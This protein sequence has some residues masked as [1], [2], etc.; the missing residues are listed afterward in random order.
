MPLGMNLVTEEFLSAV[1]ALPKAELHLHIEGT[2]EPAMLMRLAEKHSVS[3][4]YKSE[5]EVHAA[6]DFSDLQSFLDIYYLGAGVLI[7]EAD[8]HDL[9]FTYL[10]RCRDEGIVHT[11]IMFDPQTHTDR[12]ISFGT[13]MDGFLK[14]MESAQ[15]DWGQSSA[16]IM[17]F[18]RHLD[19]DSAFQTLNQAEPYRAHIQSVGLD[20]SE[21]GHPPEKFAEVYAEA[22]SQGYRPVAHA[23]EEGPPEYI[24]GAL[25]TL[26]V[27]R[28]DHGVRCLEDDALVQHLVE[29][30]IPLTVCPL[31]NVRLCVFPEMS[32]HPLLD[33]LDRGL[34][35]TV[36]SDDPPYFGGYLMDNFESLHEN[37]SLDLDQAKRL[38][39]NSINSS[40]LSSE[41]KEDWLTQLSSP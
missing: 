40:F 11:E 34:N 26:E 21:L 32:Q 8:F 10:S 18:L 14:A 13:V 38:A 33:M 3:L 15:R 30:Q 19:E 37:L 17:S 31:S 20:S 25:N 2:L 12:G 41:T 28:I 4:P 6:Y 24:W 35:V 16:L 7:D 9:M 1:R 23:G 22:R 5:A 39:V 27:E 29:H 36:N